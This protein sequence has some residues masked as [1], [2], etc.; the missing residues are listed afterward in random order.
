MLLPHTTV[1]MSLY[2]LDKNVM[3]R[4][5]AFVVFFCRI[6]SYGVD[7]VGVVAV[8]DRHHWQIEPVCARRVVHVDEGDAETSCQ[9]H[10]FQEKG[11]V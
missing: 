5:N 2:N 9:Q 1:L 3:N 7:G 8:T 10:G 11:L 6:T 4:T